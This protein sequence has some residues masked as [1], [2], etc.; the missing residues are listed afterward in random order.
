MVTAHAIHGHPEALRIVDLIGISAPL[1]PAQGIKP[2][3]LEHVA[4]HRACSRDN[5]FGHVAGHRTRGRC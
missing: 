1:Q 3:R 2:Q 4:G 5:G